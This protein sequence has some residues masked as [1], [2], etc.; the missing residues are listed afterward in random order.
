M[1]A[2]STGTEAAPWR[3]EHM[4]AEA[5]RVKVAVVE[6]DPFESGRRAV[7]NL[8]HTFGHALEALSAYRLRHGEAVAIGLVLAT[9]LAARLA[10]CSPALVD[11][12]ETLLDQLELPLRYD[13][14]TPE[15]VVAAMATDKK[16]VGS[17]L[18]F[19]LP[20]AI[21]DVDVYDDVPT[22][23]VLAVLAAA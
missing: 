2:S 14:P 13:G 22:D 12:V 16:R 11:R 6:E 15:Q 10:L 23:D 20:R 7:L 9:R 4:I 8:G 19:V 18:R 21:G 17:H 1:I 5:V 3:L